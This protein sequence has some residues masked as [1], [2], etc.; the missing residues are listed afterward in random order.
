MTNQQRAVAVLTEDK[1]P[2]GELEYEMAD[3]VKLDVSL[4]PDHVSDELAA[5]TLDFVRS[6]LRQPGGREMLDAKTAARKKR[7]AVQAAK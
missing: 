2:L 5:A 4:I 7:Q 3:S 1:Y 6:I